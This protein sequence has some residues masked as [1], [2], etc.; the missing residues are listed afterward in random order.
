MYVSK[1]MYDSVSAMSSLGVNAFESK[2]N[3]TEHEYKTNRHMSSPYLQQTSISMHFDF[4][5]VIIN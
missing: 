5:Y 2:N 1:F 3:T 4:H